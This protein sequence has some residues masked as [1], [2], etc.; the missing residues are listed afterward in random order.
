[1]QVTMFKGLFPV[2]LPDAWFANPKQIRL[3]R[4]DGQKQTID[5][6][7]NGGRVIA[8]WIDSEPGLGATR[9]RWQELPEHII[10]DADWGAG[11]WAMESRK[12]IAMYGQSG[13]PLDLTH[14]A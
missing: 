11:P 14:L 8:F 5:F 13:T 7:A 6:R 10:E 2:N 3:G 12:A 1:M 4:M 9:Q